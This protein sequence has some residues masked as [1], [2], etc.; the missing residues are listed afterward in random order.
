[1]NLLLLMLP[2]LVMLV[3][4]SVLD[5]R[6]R[7]IPNWLTALVAATGFIQALTWDH[8]LVNGWQAALGLIVAIAVNLPLFLLRLRGGG[9][10]KLF[11]G[12][13]VWLGPINI[14]A[15][16]IVATIVAMLVAIVQAIVTRRVGQ[17][18][19]NTASMTVGIVHGA[20]RLDA[21]DPHNADG[22]A[23]RHIPYAIP[24]L[25]AVATLI[26]MR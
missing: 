18:M 25:I 9:D 21:P 11:A 14:I 17:V 1:M 6:N 4:A 20:A 2:L 22:Y 3:I 24:I 10:V 5:L 15:V 7:R 12:V 23:T 16:F 19:R 8:A 26:A 13:G